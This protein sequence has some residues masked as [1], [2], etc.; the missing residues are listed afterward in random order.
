[1]LEWAPAYRTDGSGAGRAREGGVSKLPHGGNRDQEFERV[2]KARL[3][4]LDET[5]AGGSFYS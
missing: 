2:Y 5:P 3:E 4:R 1:M